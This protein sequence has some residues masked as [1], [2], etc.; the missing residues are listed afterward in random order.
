MFNGRINGI[1][2][3]REARI[4]QAIAELYSSSQSNPEKEAAKH[5]RLEAFVQVTRAKTISQV[6]QR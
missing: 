1:N 4:L 3:T 5:K 2:K 6:Q